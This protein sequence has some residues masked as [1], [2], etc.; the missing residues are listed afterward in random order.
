MLT[1]HFLFSVQSHA[2]NG[3]FGNLVLVQSVEVPRGALGNLIQ[4]LVVF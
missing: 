1:A 2:V 4:K 3:R